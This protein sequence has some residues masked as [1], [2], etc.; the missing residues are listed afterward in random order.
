MIAN[1]P[2]FMDWISGEL[3]E[4]E[5]FLLLSNMSTIYYFLQILEVRSLAYTLVSAETRCQAEKVDVALFD[6]RV[7]Q[8]HVDDK[9]HH[10]QH[11]ERQMLNTPHFCILSC[12][13]FQEQRDSAVRGLD[14]FWR[15]NSS[16]CLAWCQRWAS[17][18]G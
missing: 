4:P 9:E 10:E 3:I 7:H 1:V 2:Q 5:N 12:Y 17:S 18:S 16:G 14:F 8:K 11:D 6:G 13:Y 15:Q